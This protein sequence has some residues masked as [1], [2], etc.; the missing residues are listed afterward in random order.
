MNN[1]EEAETL[2][3]RI[4]D[5]CLNA[6]NLGLVNELFDPEYREHTSTAPEPLTR[7]QFRDFC[8]MWMRGF[9][10]FQFT[11]EGIIQDGERAAW[12]EHWTGTH[13]GEFMGIAPTGKRIMLE[14]L[15]Y[16]ILRNGKA[17]EHWTAIDSLALM[18]QLGVIPAMGMEPA[19]AGS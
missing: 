13:T 18:Q 10:D 8:A 2:L 1:R 6:K 11:I 12:I 14:S 7:D 3:H 9:P 17:V 16:G 19:G 5:D 4:Y 15:G